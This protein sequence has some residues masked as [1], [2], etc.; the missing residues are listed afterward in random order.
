MLIT[1]N[2]TIKYAFGTY[3]SFIRPLLCLSA[4]GFFDYLNQKVDFIDK[5]LSDSAT[6]QSESPSPP[7][8][9]MKGN[10]FIDKDG[11]CYPLPDVEF[12]KFK[13]L[14]KP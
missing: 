12:N 11:H 5:I 3:I 8:A 14:T 9:E 10:V 6:V 7:P 13:Y 1:M 4:Y 2:S